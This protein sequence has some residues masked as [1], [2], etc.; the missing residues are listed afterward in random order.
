MAIQVFKLKPNH[1]RIL[2]LLESGPM[3]RKQIMTALFLLPGN[4]PGYLHDLQNI[5]Y[6]VS[7]NKIYQLTERAKNSNWRVTREVIIDGEGQSQ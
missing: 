6:I 2:H 4:V 1:C 3:T 5:E 7:I